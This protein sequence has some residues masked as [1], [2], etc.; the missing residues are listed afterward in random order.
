MKYSSKILFILVIFYPILLLSSDLNNQPPKENDRLH[1]FYQDIQNSLQGT[2]HV[3]T[4]PV[5]WEQN[6]WF[7]FGST[8][9]GGALLFS[10]DSD[11]DRIIKR[12]RNSSLDKLANFG[13]FLG[14]PTTVITLT[15]VIYS[16][17]I[18]FKNEWAR[19]TA[20]I[21]TSSLIAGGAI[22]TTSKKLA[23]R[24]RPYMNLGKSH[25]DPFPSTDD[26]HSFVSGHTLVS[27]STALILAKRIDNIYA[28][29]FFYTLGGIGA[30]ARMYQR[31]H[32]SS[33]VFLGT[34]LS[35]A[36]V[37]AAIN[38]QKSFRGKKENKVQYSINFSYQKIM[39]NVYF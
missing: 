31:N 38:W 8:I 33:D 3:F 26:F 28:K 34:V 9:A 18:L 13:S 20:I 6:D 32:F 27:V 24:A 21:F 23:G 4:N 5:R 19:E 12:N 1:L 7:Y 14:S 22:Q 35:F 29:T 15:G 11:I 17:G 39:V 25:F 10:I 2:F 30:W 36:T 16:Y 37:S